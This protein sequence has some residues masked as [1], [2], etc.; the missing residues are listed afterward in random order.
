M[1]CVVGGRGEKVEEPGG[2][3]IGTV[4]LGEVGAMSRGPTVESD[5]LDGSPSEENVSECWCLRGDGSEGTR[6]VHFRL[7]LSRGRT[8]DEG[9]ER[10]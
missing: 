6:A 1:R 2:D 5:R 10:A 4:G 9:G 3:R 7:D 8:I